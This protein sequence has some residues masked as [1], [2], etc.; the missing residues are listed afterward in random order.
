MLLKNDPVT[1]EIC[2]KEWG[3]SRLI[4]GVWAVWAVPT[5]WPDY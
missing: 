2:G 5:P 4:R 1:G 3:T